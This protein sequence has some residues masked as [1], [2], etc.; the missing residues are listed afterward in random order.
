VRGFDTLIVSLSL[1][2]HTMTLH[3]PSNTQHSAYYGVVNYYVFRR[4]SRIPYKNS[5]RKVIGSTILDCCIHLPCVFFPQFY[6]FQSLVYEK[7]L[8]LSKSIQ[9]WKDN[10]CEDFKNCV[11]V[12]VPLDIL[13]FACI[14][15]HLRTPFVASAGLIWP[16]IMSLKRGSRDEEDK[17]NT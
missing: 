17:E 12:W 2:P 16:I 14:P 11:L 6:V 4:I 7:R 15:L 8:S 10:F 5:F 13:M 3:L 9:R 1:S